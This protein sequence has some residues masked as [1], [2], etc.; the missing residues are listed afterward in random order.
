MIKPSE[1]MGVGSR[2][3]KNKI[4]RSPTGLKSLKFSRRVAIKYG[5]R[6]G[7]DSMPA[8]V[9]RKSFATK[10]ENCSSPSGPCNS[11]LNL[12]KFKYIINTPS[13]KSLSI[14]SGSVVS[15]QDIRK[16]TKNLASMKCCYPMFISQNALQHFNAESA[17][18]T[19][20]VTYL[21]NTFTQNKRCKNILDKRIRKVNKQSMPMVNQPSIYKMDTLTSINLKV[22]NYLQRIL[23]I[24]P[25][26]KINSV[27]QDMGTFLSSIKLLTP[28]Y[29]YN[30][31]FESAFSSLS[32]MISAAVNVEIPSVKQTT[33]QGI[34]APS[35]RLTRTLKN[36]KDIRSDRRKREKEKFIQKLH[37]ES[38]LRRVLTFVNPV[39]CSYLLKDNIGAFISETD[40]KIPA[41]RSGTIFSKRNYEATK[42]I[43]KLS[44]CQIGA[45]GKDGSNKKQT[46]IIKKRFISLLHQLSSVKTELTHL[47]CKIKQKQIFE[48]YH[49]SFSFQPNGSVLSVQI[50]NLYEK[51]I[52]TSEIQEVSSYLQSMFNFGTSTKIT[53]PG[54]IF[55]SAKKV[56]RELK[57]ASVITQDA[58]ALLNQQIREIQNFQ[59]ENALEK[60]SELGRG[61]QNSFVQA[62]LIDLKYFDHTIKK[63]GLQHMYAGVT[64]NSG[65]LVFKKP[66][67]QKKEFKTENK[68]NIQTKKMFSTEIY[69]DT[70]NEFFREK[71]IHEQEIGIIADR[72]YRIIEKRIS[73]EKDRRGLF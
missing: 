16:C 50:H 68:G 67:P 53:K 31:V 43:E 55:V 7:F 11:Y 5:I 56:N 52:L 26:T 24:E 63:A 35:P 70:L 29:R 49:N 2:S 46:G 8:L 30:K 36:D 61:Y 39:I 22:F 59:Y 17:E 51:N 34:E 48:R 15:I 32:E 69:E 6:Y 41:V 47:G 20:S 21:H 28:D 40:S 66:A 54:R 57:I 18:K 13:K 62:P 58:N 65:E 71:K 45:L 14:S 37:Q 33:A 12:R 44:P 23:N 25:S 10:T 60:D 42:A 27:T 1:M 9:F 73:I 38:V 72:V 64:Y 19:Y 4:T 3:L